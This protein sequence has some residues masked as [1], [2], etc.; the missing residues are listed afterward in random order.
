MMGRALGRR[1]RGSTVVAIVVIV[2]LG[3]AASARAENPSDARTEARRHYDTATAA[4]A[5]G[6]YDDAATEFERAFT[7]KPDPAILYNAAQA[8]RLAGKK[9]RALELY[10]SYLR[11]YGRRAEH[12]S[13]VDWHIGE[14][15]K[16]IERDRRAAPGA[17]AGLTAGDTSLAAPLPPLAPRPAAS[18]VAAPPAP[19]ARPVYQR[20]WFWAG[21]GAIVVGAIVGIALATR[22]A[23]DCGAG[24]TYCANTG[25]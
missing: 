9:E 23:P 8:Y 4:Y 1:A 24:V 17:R 15:E 13:D 11:V 6:H 18:L 10:R 2:A 25:L 16:V 20:W 12:A 14:L 19:R 3:T 21:A 22:G 5:L 7:L